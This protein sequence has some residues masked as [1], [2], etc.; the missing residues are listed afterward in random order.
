MSFSCPVNDL[1][2]ARFS[3]RSY[4]ARPLAPSML[5][6][7]EHFIRT[8]LQPPFGSK[9]RYIITAASDSTRRELKNLGTYGYIKSSSA[10]IIGVVKRG[11]KDLEEF[12]YT[13]EQI[14]LS[15]TDQGLGT[16]WLGGTFTRSTFNQKINPARDEIFPA[17]VSLGY[18]AL[19]PAAT[20]KLI[21][22]AVGAQRR[23]PW[24]MLFFKEAFGNS[25]LP[26]SA[27]EYS[28]P[29]EMLRLAPSAS[30]KQPWRVLLQDNAFHFYL[31]RTPGYPGFLAT[32][33]LGVE[34]IQ[35]VDMGIAMCHFELSAREQ[36][37]QGQWVVSQ[38][39]Q[40]CP[41]NTEYSTSWIIK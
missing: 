3:C 10:F 30:N 26:E 17:A 8:S 38:P 18:P 7:M 6:T 36:G 1:I 5:V 32:T 12:G 37:L 25:L 31:Q 4:D 13:L 35:R 23:M 41:P 22:R 2:K 27:A 15:A 40:K 21:R 16:C 9:V 28:T 39:S 29:L 34:D 19:H 14:I 11:E 20:S 33:L 24:E